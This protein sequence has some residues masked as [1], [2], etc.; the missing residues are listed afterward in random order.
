MKGYQ[1]PIRQ[2]RRNG[3][4]VASYT[5]PRLY[6]KELENLNILITNKVVETLIE[7]LPKNKSQRPDCFSRES[8][9]TFKEDLTSILFKLFQKLKRMEYLL[10]HF[11]MPTI[12]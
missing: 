5:L 7:N 9:Q 1:S 8:Y 3:H 4:F 11:K 10:T 12:P 2:P 6:H